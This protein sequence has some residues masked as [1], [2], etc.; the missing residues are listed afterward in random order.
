MESV[1]GTVGNDTF[2][3][4]HATLQA[5]DVLNGG[6]GNDTLVIIDS[7]SAAFTAPAILASGIENVTIRNVNGTPAVAGVTAVNEVQEVTV[8]GAAVGTSTTF[9]GVATTVVAADNAA[10]VGGKIIANKANILAGT[11]AKN[12]GII[13]IVAGATNDLIR[14]VFTSQNGNVANIASQVTNN[15]SSFSAGVEVTAGAKGVT[16]VSATG[17]TDTVAAGTYVGATTFNNDN[18]TSAVTYTGLAST[19]VVNVIGNTATTNGDTSAT[20]STATSPTLNLVGGTTA[21]AITVTANAAS[22]I[23]LGSSGV[24][25]TSTGAIGTNTVGSVNLGG[26]STSTLAIQADSNIALTTGSTFT[27]AAKDIVVSGGATSVNLGAGSSGTTAISATNLE[28]INA[29]G[30]T[31]GGVAVALTTGTKSF[32][33]GQGSDTVATA[34][35]TNTGVVVDGGAGNDTLIIS[36]ATDLD[37]TAEAA[38][39]KN[40][41]TV[42]AAAGSFDA[43][44]VPTATAIQVTGAGTLSGLNATQAAAVQVRTSGQYTFALADSTGTSDV[45]TLSLGTGTTTSAATSIST[46][47]TAN[48]FETIN[49]KTNAGSTSTVGANKTSTIAAFTADK[50]TAINL[51]GNAFVLSNIATTKAVTID[52]SALTGDGQATPAGLTVAGNAAVGSTVTGSSFADTFTLGTVG[53]TYNAGAGND[54]IKS[55]VAT[56]LSGGVYNTVDAGA[57]TDTLQIT[58]GAGNAVTLIDNSFRNVSNIEKITVDSTTTAATSI[59]TGG[60]FDKAFATNGVEITATTSTGN[61]TVDASTF[62][63]SMK[64]TAT[65]VGTGANGAV[66]VTTGSGN[67]TVTVS[68]ATAGTDGVISTG[69]GNDTITGGGDADTITGGTGA[70]TMTG[71]AGADTFVFA[72]GDTGLPS[73]TNFDVITDFT[74]NSDII[75]LG[76]YSIVTYTSTTAGTASISAAGIATFQTADVTLA[77]RIVATENGINAGGTATAGQTAVFQYLND[78]YI[79]VSDGVDGVGA[80]DRL[81]KLVGIDTTNAATDTVTASTANVSFVLA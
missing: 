65:S 77:Q 64:V 40:F 51:T 80:N 2:N 10:T 46:G 36:A 30:M 23:T 7:G 52:G 75:N 56:L 55:T 57:G 19:N 73:A 34:A 74:T 81:I 78:A 31:A 59:T 16:A 41:E 38:V 49:L 5:G 25:A 6:A 53:S 43:S 47:L 39:Y 61:L 67:D 8:T 18:S 63:G 33:G 14:L 11:E 66:S 28:T 68:N 15:G 35:F 12:L 26:L 4:T 13:D 69:A 60:W 54:T 24:P 62:T 37:T 79:F 58:D 22:K 72:A 71:G 42:R 45:L 20:W 32:I 1:T 29:S 48:G 27:T 3:A 17:Y 9:L 50:A 76:A 70:D 44:L 21:G